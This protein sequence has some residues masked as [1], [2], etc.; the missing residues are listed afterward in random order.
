LQKFD[1]TVENFVIYILFM[2]VTGKLYLATV[3]NPLNKLWKRF[4]TR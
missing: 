4:Q 2:S 1:E 3:Y